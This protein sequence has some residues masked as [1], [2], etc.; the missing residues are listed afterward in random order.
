MSDLRKGWLVAVR[1]MRERSRSRAFRASLVVMLLIV[2]AIVVVPAMLS[3]GGGT[4]DVGLTGAVA[5]Q[6]PQAIGDQAEAL[7]V[8]VAVHRYDSVAAGEEAAR[9]GDIDVLVVDAQRLMWRRQA[10]EQLRSILT[11]AIQLVAVQERATAAGISPD[12]LL[13]MVAPVPV[14]SV[15]IGSVAGRSP[16]DEMAAIVMTVLLFFAIST[17]GSLV[18]TGVVEE[19]SSRVVEVLLARVPARS[20]LAGKLAGIGLLG[21]AQFGVTALVA[22]VATTM[23]DSIDLPA[24]SAGVLAW[25]VVWFVLGYALYATVYGA[26]GS[27]ASR[28]EDAQSVSGPVMVVLMAGYF[29]SF[30]AVGRPDSGLAQLASQFPATAP[31][32][33]P[34]RIAMGAVE[35]WEP[36]LAVALTVGA[37][38]ALVQF[39]ARVYAGAILHSGPTLRLRDAWRRPTALRSTTAA[40]SSPSLIGAEVGT[41]VAEEPSSLPLR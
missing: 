5:E 12:A 36:I 17:Y 26:L 11:G 29:A 34:N 20:L 19:K 35:W 40:V 31:L 6:L 18:L 8:T 14:E 39:G 1:E 15:E 3:D 37:I 41:G 23:V 10:D 30:V 9:D 28:T 38:V 21:L 25:V 4:V 22:L 2:L 7:G 24:V 33:M 13:E 27:L 16:D 32:A